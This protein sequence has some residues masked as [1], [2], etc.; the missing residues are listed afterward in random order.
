L[1]E[2]KGFGARIKGQKGFGSFTA[3][4]RSFTTSLQTL[5][6]KSGI[7]ITI[8][9]PNYN[10]AATSNGFIDE[11]ADDLIKSGK[12]AKAD[13]VGV[14]ANGFKELYENANVNDI[15]SWVNDGLDNN[16]KMN[17]KFKENYFKFAL[18]YY[19]NQEDFEY[20]LC[21]G[22]SPKPAFLFGAMSFL[23]KADILSG[24]INGKVAIDSWPS[25]LPSAGQGGGVF[26][27]RP[28]TQ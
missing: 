16:G 17:Q 2:I 22:T 15:A 1:Y 3:V 5:I 9:N 25:F 10:I 28:V 14:Y 23:S 11:I 27:I 18:K 8:T 24:N 4:A 13:I 19:A 7:Q 6:A 21:I 20:V 26:A 12:I